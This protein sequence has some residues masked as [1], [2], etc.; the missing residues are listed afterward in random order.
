MASPDSTTV[1]HRTKGEDW[2][3]P[4][5]TPATHQFDYVV[6]LQPGD[7]LF[8]P[9]YWWHYVETTNRGAMVNFWFH[10]V[11]RKRKRATRSRTTA[12]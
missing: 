5:S 1:L 2:E 10:Q 3:A 11:E 7:V 9:R 4:E 6:T 12:Q 8:I